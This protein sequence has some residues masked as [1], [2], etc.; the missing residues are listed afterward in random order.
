M[1]RAVTS[2]RDLASVQM[3]NALNAHRN[4]EYGHC[5]TYVLLAQAYLLDSIDQTL[6]TI[7]VELQHGRSR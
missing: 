5:N 1:G 3:S 6:T 4:Q 2:P 7:L